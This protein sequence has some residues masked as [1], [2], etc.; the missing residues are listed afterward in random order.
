M[1]ENRFFVLRCP[2]CGTF[3]TKEIRK[4]HSAIFKCFKCN[5]TRK[6]YRK[7]DFNLQCYGRYTCNDATSKIKILKEN[8]VCK[9]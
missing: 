1:E 9:I 4:I 8:I 6:V 5:K 3:Q 2:N 7:G